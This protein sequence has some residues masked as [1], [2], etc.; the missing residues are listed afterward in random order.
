MRRDWADIC[1]LWDGDSLLTTAGM[2]SHGTAH[3]LPLPSPLPLRAAHRSPSH[4]LIREPA[5]PSFLLVT[6]CASYLSKTISLPN[7]IIRSSAHFYD[8]GTQEPGISWLWQQF[9]F[10]KHTLPLTPVSLPVTLF[11]WSSLWQNPSKELSKLTVS[12]ASPLN[13]S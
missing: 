13:L 12:N 3:Q 2:I 4:S 8:I 1:W 7:F 6:W 9:H 10:N 5:I 11:L